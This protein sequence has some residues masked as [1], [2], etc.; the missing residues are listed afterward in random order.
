VD[1]VEKIAAIRLER[2]SVGLFFAS[3]Y[4]HF[5]HPEK[6]PITDSFTRRAVKHLM[7]RNKGKYDEY[8]FFKQA[9]DGMISALHGEPSYKEMDVY[10]YLLGQWIEY[11]SMKRSSVNSLEARRVESHSP[12]AYCM[13]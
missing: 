12:T 13:F 4:C 5:H 11:K 7:E 3:K 1:N 9:I 8:G 2:R 6:Y 10:L